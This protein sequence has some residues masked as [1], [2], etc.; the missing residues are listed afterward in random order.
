M[1]V[2]DSTYDL[3]IRGGTIVDGSGS[4]PFVGDVAVRGGWIVATG[5]VPGRG[6]QEIQ[7]EGLLVTPG[8]VDIHT[9]YDGQL[10]WSER[11]APSSDHGVTTVVVGN[12]GIGF[13]PCRAKDRQAL[14][15]LMEGVEDIPGAVTD[16]GLT[17]EWESFPDYLDALERRK[18]DIDI[19]VLIPHS[20]IR[21]Y[22]M[23]ERALRREPANAADRAAMRQ[24]TREGLEAGALG[25]GTSRL[26]AHRS[27]SGELIPTFDAEEAELTEIAQEMRAA[28]KGVFQIVTN[29]GYAPFADQFPLLRRLAAVAG[30]PLTYTHPQFPKWRECLTLLDE[31]N[32][33]PGVNIK[34]QLLPRPVGMMLGLS[35]SAQPFCM[36]P[37]YLRIK[38]LPLA[39]RVARMR[40]PELRRA[41]L[42]EEPTDPTNPLVSFVRRWDRIFA[43]GRTVDYEP[44]LDKSIAELARAQGRTPGEVAY[45]ELLKEDGKSLLML[46]IGNYE[47]G[48][49]DWMEEM[50]GSGNVVLGLGDGG[51][52][53]GMI[54]DASFTTFAL[55][56]W[57]RDRSRGRLALEDVVHRLT[58]EPALLMG[59]EDRGLVAE[60]YRA[61]LNVI[62]YDKLS[63][64][65][66]NVV[67]DLPAGG[68][69]LHQT[70]DGYVAT[71][72]SGRVIARNGK[73]TD[74]RPGRL[75]RGRQSPR[76]HAGAAAA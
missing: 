50:F 61:N 38:D 20:P 70:A 45:D 24:L 25:F 32:E 15:K 3:V 14:I 19:G 73:A 59:L 5:S 17:W 10:I 11:V 1:R 6:A 76:Q 29:A 23:G 22:T 36:T 63:L 43:T 27:S 57:T 65:K 74:E 34:A 37:S 54:C 60:G 72:V 41:I 35:I 40:E 53:Y 71:I 49:L 18:H 56:Y 16:V 52:H 64:H 46:T 69:R 42:S 28:D 13:A 31:A 67:T 68:K 66:P 55:S 51:A 2:S 21:V 47:T 26:A 12:C 62:D 7:A 58:R 44:G 75:I 30:R 9:H 33:E 4:A 39:E 48:S 8:F